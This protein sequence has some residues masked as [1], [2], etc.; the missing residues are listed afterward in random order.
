MILITKDEWFDKI[1]DCDCDIARLKVEMFKYERLRMSVMCHVMIER[2]K[3][4]MPSEE[5]LN[6]Q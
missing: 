3:L 2:R 5:N 4:R 6:E 1:F